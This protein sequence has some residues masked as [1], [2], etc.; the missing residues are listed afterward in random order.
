MYLT[1][2]LLGPSLLV[3]FAVS[4][5]FCE[6]GVQNRVAA[7]G[8]HCM[9]IDGEGALWTWGRNYAGNWGDERR[10]IRMCQSVSVRTRTGSPF[11]PGIT[12]ACN[13]AGWVAMGVGVQPFRAVGIGTVEDA[14]SPAEIKGGKDWVAL[15]AG[16]YH[17]IGPEA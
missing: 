11:R 8:Y 3:V 10:R 7:G 9:A 5:G 2:S 12:I 6:E 16:D 13:E 1:G 4:N 15:T 17:T 14:H